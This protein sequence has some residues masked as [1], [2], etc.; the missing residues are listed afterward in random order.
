M[1]NPSQNDWSRLLEDALCRWECHP[2]GLSLA[3]LVTYW[4]RLS[5]KFIGRSRSAIWHMTK[6]TE[7]ENYS[8]RSWRSYAWKLTRTPESTRKEFSVSQ[9]SLSVRSVPG[10]MGPFVVTNVF[11]YGTVE[12]RDEA[13]NNTFKV[14]VYQLK[15]YHEGPN[16]NSTMGEVEII[17]LMEPVIL[18]D[19]PDKF[20]FV[21]VLQ[22]VDSK[23]STEFEPTLVSCRDQVYAD[24]ISAGICRLDV[25]KS[26]L[27]NLDEFI[28]QEERYEKQKHQSEA[29]ARRKKGMGCE[30]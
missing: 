7:S 16:L 11:P 1:A 24:S 27:E 5:I 6:P 22:C 10:G 14:N 17:T 20:C 13:N 15:P 4:S 25:G 9:K 2:T 3:K 28:R 26:F 8:C 29:M 19:P 23:F 21:F 18:E 12:V 30:K